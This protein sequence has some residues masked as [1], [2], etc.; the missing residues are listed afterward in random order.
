MLQAYVK[1][2]SRRPDG[3]YDS[4]QTYSVDVKVTGR[5]WKGRTASGYGSAMPTEYMVR[6]NNRWQRVKVICYANSGTAYIG[7]EFDPQ[8]TVDIDRGE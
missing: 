7:S 6:W 3:S 4:Y 5:P 1:T 2:K 8:L